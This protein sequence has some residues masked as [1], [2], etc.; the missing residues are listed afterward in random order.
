ME[1]KNKLEPS[2]KAEGTCMPTTVKQ[3]WLQAI[4]GANEPLFSVFLTCVCSAGTLFIC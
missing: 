2:N 3:K 4:I 1:R